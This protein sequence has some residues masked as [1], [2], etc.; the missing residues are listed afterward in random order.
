MRIILKR[1]D[2]ETVQSMMGLYFICGTPNTKDIHTTLTE[3]CKGGITCFQFREKGEG[4]LIGGQKEQ[5]AREL[6]HICKEYGVPFIVN[7]DV[8]LAERIGAD[9][10][11]VGQDDMD[12]HKKRCQNCTRTRINFSFTCS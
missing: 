9:G 2:I 7:D 3:A 10:V 12:K 6:Q 8:E 1:Y 11:H 4:A 5:M